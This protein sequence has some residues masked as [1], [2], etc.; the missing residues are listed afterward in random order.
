LEPQG[1]QEQQEAVQILLDLAKRRDIFFGDAVEAA[2]Q[3]YI[4]SP[5]G[6]QAR[7]LG[8]EMLLAQA[9]WPDVTVAQAQ[10]AALA[11]AFARG[12]GMLSKD[13]NRAIEVLIELAQRP[14][15]SFEDAVVLDERRC[16]VDSNK[17]LV[18]QQLA[19]KKQMWEAVA[20]RSDLTPA[21]RLE[22]EQA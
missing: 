4:Q 17:A 3:L 1:S 12:R 8:A 18:K 11:L 15:L 22:V 21:Q 6:S 20:L 13:W 7:E 10:E 19:A 5:K 2:Y 9:R 14:G 16:S